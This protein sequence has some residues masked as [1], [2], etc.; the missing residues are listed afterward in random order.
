MQTGAFS[1]CRA[2]GTATTQHRG[3][4]CSPTL[5]QTTKDVVSSVQRAVEPPCNSF[6]HMDKGT[7]PGNPQ[8]PQCQEMAPN[9]ACLWPELVSA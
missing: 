8:E 3:R 2:Q 9:P 7:Q 5:L 4:D 1:T 6:L